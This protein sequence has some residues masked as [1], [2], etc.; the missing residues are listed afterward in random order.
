MKKRLAHRDAFEHDPQLVLAGCCPVCQVIQ[1]GRIS[2]TQ[3]PAQRVG[4]QVGDESANEPLLLFQEQLLELRQCLEFVLVEQNPADIDLASV[5]VFVA[6]DP[7]RAVVFQGEA[8]RVDEPICRLIAV[9][10]VNSPSTR[11]NTGFSD[12][13]PIGDCM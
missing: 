3:L 12:A 11:R 8:R 6:P 9:S 13:W 10:E 5:L 7:C 2:R 1:G 4:E